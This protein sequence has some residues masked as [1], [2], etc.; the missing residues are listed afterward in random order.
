[1][2]IYSFLCSAFFEAYA[3]LCSWLLQALVLGLFPLKY[4]IKGTPPTY[5]AFMN[6]EG[7]VFG[8]LFIFSAHV[9]FTVSYLFMVTLSAL[10]RPPL[11][12]SG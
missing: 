11:L 8:D 12:P 3:S 2:E 4:R 10:R 9:L 5:L 6:D 1:M 7:D